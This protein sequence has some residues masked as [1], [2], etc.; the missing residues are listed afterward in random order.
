VDTVTSGNPA[1]T[2]GTQTVSVL[3]E[4]LLLERHVPP[5]VIANA[6]GEIVYVHGHTGAYLEPAPGPPPQHLLDMVRE[7]LKYELS[8]MLQQAAGPKTEVIRRGIRVKANGAINMVNVTIRRIAEPEALRGLS[9]VTFETVP[10][11]RKQEKSGSTSSSRLVR[12]GLENELEE[13][14]RRLQHT[15]EELQTSNEELKSANEELQSTNEELQSTNEELETAKEELQSLNEE[16]VTVNAELQGKL[17]ELSGVNDDLANLFNS[18]EVATI[19]VDNDLCIKRFTPE[20]K[21]VVNLILSDVGRPLSDISSK[22]VSNQMFEDTREVLQTLIFKEREVQT[23]DGSWFYMRI[24]P[25][26]TAKNTIEGLVLTFLNITK[27]KLAEQTS[28]AALTYAQGI[29]ETID[30]PLIVLDE[31]LRVVSANQ[32]FYRIFRLTPQ[33]VE[34]QLIYNLGNGMLN[35]PRLRKLLEQ[36]LPH[37]T[38]FEEF[39]IDQEFPELGRKVLVLKAIRI[40]Q[41]ATK[42]ARI[43]LAI[44]DITERELSKER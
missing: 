3:I 9:W 20:A 4:Q 22:L 18:T 28:E 26:R 5:S 11:A 29:V 41:E 31:E 23:T 44:D 2:A 35:V 21:K 7:G 12:T 19:F 6:Q 37:D 40:R 24:L 15:I 34:H 25:Y 42:P 10:A 43:L 14:K 36:I 16:L 13:T 27:T 39:V 1:G 32:A 33:K 30:A 8:S 38:P 17:E